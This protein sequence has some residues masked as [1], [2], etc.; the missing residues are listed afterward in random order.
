VSWCEIE[1]RHALGAQP[2]RKVRRLPGIGAHA[3]HIEPRAQVAQV[4]LDGAEMGFVAG[5]DDEVAARGP[6]RI[7][8]VPRL[9]DGGLVQVARA[10]AV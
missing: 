5:R 10:N 6:T 1:H 9:Q 4:I 3:L 7:A 2:L 8:R